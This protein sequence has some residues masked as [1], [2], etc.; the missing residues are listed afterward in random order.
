MKKT[1]ATLAVIVMALCRRD[2]LHAANWYWDGNGGVAGGSLGGSGPWNST[3]L[4]W[5]THP[6]NPLTNWVAGNAPLFNGDPG[7]V[8]LTEDVPIAV[9]MTVNADMTF[10]GAYRLTLSGGTHVTAV[11]KT[12]TV[13][14]AVQLLYNTAIRYNYVIN[15]NISD[16]GASRSIT[17][18]FETLTLNGSNSFGGGVA[19]NGGALV[20]GNDHAL[21]TGN[22]LLGYDG[23]V[24]KAGGGDPTVAN[25]FNW[26]WNWRLNFQ[27]TNDLTC[28]VTQTLYGTAT[29]WPRFSIVEPGTTLTYGGLKRNPLYHTMMVKEGAG[30]FLIRGPYD[31]SYGT[32]VSNGLLVLNGATT[33]VQNN[34]GYTV[35][36]GGS[37]GGTGTV[38]LAASGSTCTVQQAGALAPGAT[39]GTSVGIL[40]FNGPVSLAENSIYQWDC[41]DGTGDLIVVNGTLTL[42]SVATVRVNR[43]SGALPADSVILTAGTLAGDGALENW[44]VQGFPRARV[45]IRGTD[46]ILYWPPGSVFLIQ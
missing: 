29:P 44:G 19:L 15:G 3:S 14:C 33:A 41:Q 30:T 5:R 26:N 10:N 16:D 9:S 18:H 43:V 17:H 22:L 11:A 6:N 31:A 42:P 21:G 13:N 1:V 7:T 12:A 45:R 40:T 32:I 8:T 2:S 39:S 34:Y 28:T 37:L 23:A 46:V 20:I 4:V 25:R 38:N 24:V 35:C 36:A 27:G